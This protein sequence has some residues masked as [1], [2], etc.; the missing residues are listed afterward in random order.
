MA[1]EI[2]VNDAAWN[3]L[4]QEDRD[5][6]NEILTQSFGQVSIKADPNTPEP[7]AGASFKFPGGSSIC[8]LLCDLAGTAGHIACK[9]LPEPAQAICDAGVDAG[10]GLCKSKCG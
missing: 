8:K 6:I 5:A 2:T 3:A 1:D 9:R 10:V 7:A 4:G